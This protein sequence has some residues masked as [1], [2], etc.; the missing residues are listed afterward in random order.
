[1]KVIL[2]KLRG[3]LGTAITW[4]V[5]WAIGGFGLYS[6]LYWLTPGVV[7]FWPGAAPA[8]A[9]SAASGFV[10]GTV[11]STV[12]TTFFARKSLNELSPAGMGLW[13]ALCGLLVPGAIIGLGSVL[14]AGFGVGTGVI[15]LTA[16]GAFGA[17]TGYGMVKLAQAGSAEIGSGDADWMLDSGE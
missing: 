15:T 13:G 14:S 9:I 6:L 2:R 5:T 10:G 11:F 8:T 4:A 3:G 17:T 1:M 12:L 7:F 16:M